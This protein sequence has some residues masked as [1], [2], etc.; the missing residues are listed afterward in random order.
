MPQMTIASKA[1]RKLNTSWVNIRGNL[2]KIDRT[3]PYRPQEGI[4]I[5]EESSDETATFKFG[6]LVLH[7]PEKPF[8]NS[9]AK[10]YV[11]IKGN[12]TLEHSGG[13][14]LLRTRHYQTQIG[15]FREKEG[16]LNHVFGAHYDLDPRFAHPVFHAQISPQTDFAMDV[17][18]RFNSIHGL[19]QDGDWIN[20]LLRNVRVPTSQMDFFAVL[21][22]VISDHLINEES[23]QSA[24]DVYLELCK[25]CRPFASFGHNHIGLKKSIDAKC[26]GSSY[27]YDH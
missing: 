26:F 8:T 16:H 3:V 17:S 18:K 9:K 10:L 11:V 19:R 13:S 5:L 27:W 15:Y 24:R 1:N 7:L 12:L 23:P 21:L 4:V 2:R 14:D 25:N 6:P 20:G 22:Q